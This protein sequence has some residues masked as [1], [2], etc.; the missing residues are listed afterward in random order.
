MFPFTIFFKS[1]KIS[2]RSV[3]SSLNSTKRTDLLLEPSEFTKNYSPI[4]AI[5]L[6][7]FDKDEPYFTC[8]EKIGLPL[9]V[10][11]GAILC[12]V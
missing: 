10:S 5:S 7:Q 8:D 11:G 6:N 3:Q 1:C 12:Y 4:W 2:T 9:R